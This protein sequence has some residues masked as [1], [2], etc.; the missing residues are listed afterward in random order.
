MYFVPVCNQY[1]CISLQ[2]QRLRNRKVTGDRIVGPKLRIRVTRGCVV[3]VLGTVESIYD[4]N[5]KGLELTSKRSLGVPCEIVYI[6]E[7][8]EGHGLNSICYPPYAILGLCTLVCSMHLTYLF[9]PFYD[10]MWGPT[11]RK[12]PRP[13]V[14]MLQV[15]SLRSYHPAWNPR[16]HIYIYIYIYFFTSDSA[17]ISFICSVVVVH[18]LTNHFNAPRYH[19]DCPF[20]LTSCPHA[21]TIT[22]PNYIPQRHHVQISLDLNNIYIYICGRNHAY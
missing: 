1:F 14:Y 2:R 3:K 10:I 13:C 6:L 17:L 16:V 12:Y 5:N 22:D 4:S 7:M 9:F 18:Q 21:T 8:R 15:P 19:D 11:R 20:T